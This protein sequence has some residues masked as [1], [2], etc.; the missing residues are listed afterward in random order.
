MSL[1]TATRVKAPTAMQIV[2]SASLP[3]TTPP[4][5]VGAAVAQVAPAEALAVLVAPVVPTGE[6]AAFPRKSTTSTG[7][8]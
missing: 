3:P 8:F 6:V 4:M 1:L 7:S 2:V 5:A